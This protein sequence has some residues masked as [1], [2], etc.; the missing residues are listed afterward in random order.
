MTRKY[1]RRTVRPLHNPLIVARNQAACLT[2]SELAE[3]LDPLR[4]AAAR[5]RQGI[6][7]EDDHA[8]LTG[9]IMMAQSIE[10]QGVVRGLAGHLADIA[11]AL[12]TVG[13]RASEGRAWFAPTLYFH[14]IEAVQLFLELHEFQL[15]QLSFREFRRALNLTTAHVRSARIPL[16]QL[17]AGAT[18]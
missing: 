7:S 6:A 13:A 5:L 16:V 18:G 1:T 9:S 17:G 14:E 12:A 3:V 11:R 8:M 2:A 4:A 10:Q 15:R